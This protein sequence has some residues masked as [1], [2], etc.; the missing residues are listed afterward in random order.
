MSVRKVFA[1]FRFRFRFLLKIKTLFVFFILQKQNVLLIL[2]VHTNKT[3]CSFEWCILLPLWGKITAYF[4]FPLLLRK[5]CKWSRLHVLQSVLQ[6][7]LLAQTIL[8]LSHIYLTFFNLYREMHEVFYD[9]NR[10]FLRRLNWSNICS[11]HGLAL[12]AWYLKKNKNLNLTN[13]KCSNH[14]S[15]LT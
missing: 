3:I 1:E 8:Y 14:V 15:K 6:L 2:W 13:I 9:S 7:P 12:A 4:N 5:K 10:V 11:T